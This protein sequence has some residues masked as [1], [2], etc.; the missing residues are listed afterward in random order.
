MKKCKLVVHSKIC[1][2]VL[3]ELK[4]SPLVS[5]LSSPELVLALSTKFQKSGKSSASLLLKDSLA[6]PTRASKIRNIIK[7]ADHNNTFIPYTAIEALAFI[8]E[9]KL[10]KQQYTNIRLGALR[11][12]KCDI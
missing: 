7:N 11:K 5:S 2:N 4:I 10:T 1:L 3:T 6:S 12:Y 8:I 9:N